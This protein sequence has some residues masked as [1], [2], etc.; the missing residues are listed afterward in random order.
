MDNQSASDTEVNPLYRKKSS[1]LIKRLDKLPNLRYDD[2]SIGEMIVKKSMA[3]YFYE[4]STK[5]Y[6]VVDKCVK[7]M[8]ETKDGELIKQLGVSVRE[9]SA[10]KSMLFFSSG[11]IKSFIKVSDLEEIKNEVFS[12]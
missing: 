3:P 7:D 4:K 9:M 1:L 5:Y 12:S 2:L 11:E 6:I 10:K 8:G